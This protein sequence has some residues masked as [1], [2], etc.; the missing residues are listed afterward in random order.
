MNWHLNWT[1]LRSA[2]CSN[3]LLLTE[4]AHSFAFSSFIMVAQKQSW[5]K[6]TCRYHSAVVAKNANLKP[7]RARPRS[8]RASQS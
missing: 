6:F 1:K 3:I 2:P 8:A 7:R 5:F 4:C